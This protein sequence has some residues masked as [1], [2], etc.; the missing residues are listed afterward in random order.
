MK[1]QIN[2]SGAIYE[3]QVTKEKY[4]YIF[5]LQRCDGFIEYYKPFG[6][7]RF[8]CS[9]RCRLKHYKDF[10]KGIFNGNSTLKKFKTIM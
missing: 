3:A 4:F 5:R 6:F 9:I 2:Y 7:G 1:L 10:K 8:S